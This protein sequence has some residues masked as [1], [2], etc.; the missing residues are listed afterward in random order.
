MKRL[1]IVF[2]I[3]F[4]LTFVAFSKSF[5][6]VRG[7]FLVTTTPNTDEIK[8]HC[9]FKNTSD[10][11]INIKLNIWLVEASDN[12]EVS[13]CWGPLCYPPLE[14]NELREP[15]DIITLQPGQISGDNEFYITFLPNGSEGRAIV[16]AVLFDRDDPADSLHLTFQLVSSLNVDDL[17]YLVSFNRILASGN[18]ELEKFGFKSEPIYIFSIDGSLTHTIWVPS[19][20]NFSTLPNG[21]YLLVQFNP[22]HKKL[23]INK[24]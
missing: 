19:Q 13:F 24:F 5:E 18:L 22:Q 1:F 23:I 17:Q 15:M 7:D 4:S 20:F 3:G 8:A 12:L 21:I 6:I 11:E 9:V 10:K 2:L 16:E 14:I